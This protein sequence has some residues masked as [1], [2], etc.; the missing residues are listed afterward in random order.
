MRQ[1]SCVSMVCTRDNL[2]GSSRCTTMNVLAFA[3]STTFWDSRVVSRHASKA[4]LAN[5]CPQ[6]QV[7]FVSSKRLLQRRYRKSAISLREKV[8][9]SR[10]ENKA[11]QQKPSQSN[12]FADFLK[13][14]ILQGFDPTPELGAILTVYFV[15]GALG[16]SRLALSFF[17]KDELGLHPA[18]V[19]SLTA[20]AM[21]PWLIKP[22]Y[23]FLS[24]SLPVFGYRRRSYLVFAGALGALSWASLA[25]VANSVAAVA[26]A[27]IA[28]AGSVAISDVVADSLVVERV[29]GLP[30]DRSGALQSLCW[31]FSAF[32]G[33]L[34]AYLSGSL[35]EMFTA[36]QIFAGTAILPLATASLSVLI[37]ETST[38]IGSLQQ[39]GRT[40]KS[41]FTSLWQALSRRSVYLPVLF[42]FLWQASP[43]PDS[44]M[45][46]FNTTVLGFG[47]EFLGRVRLASAAAALI[48]LWSYQKYFKQVEVKTLMLGASI[49]GLP[50]ALTQ[51]L[52]VTRVNVSL[53]ISDQI[54]AMT[55]TAVLAALGQVAF[56]P[57]LVLAARLCPPGVEGTLF[58][59][60]MSIYNASGATSNQLGSLLTKALHITDSDFTNLWELI[61]ICAV[62]G[63]LPLPLLKLVDEA[64]KDVTDDEFDQEAHE[65]LSGSENMHAGLHE[66][67][68]PVTWESHV[69][70]K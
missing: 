60:L 5:F 12:S 68:M 45:F 47:P 17:M 65:K 40:F 1:L 64:P 58:A 34:S 46:F 11:E 41:R 56:M 20:I 54:F 37:P 44:A 36:R 4:G 52:L 42:I 3:S 35:L 61:V 50:L 10:S 18:E 38:S 14:R 7:A 2:R 26:I 24:D 8:T 23:G 6:R 62:S 9:A 22:L 33:L 29:R 16:I 25:T 67:E 48:G 66:S 28:T 51:L 53:G 19:A 55:D 59:T 32:G 57:T 69:H 43:N 21:L 13:H 49:V 70:K 39:L 30:S 27:S 31:A 63:L 15:Q